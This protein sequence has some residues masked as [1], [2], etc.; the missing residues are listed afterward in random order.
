MRNK[1]DWDI[2]DVVVALHTLGCDNKWKVDRPYDYWGYDIY[3]DG[4]F[5][6]NSTAYTPSAIAGEVHSFINKQIEDEKKSVKQ[7]SKDFNI[8]IEYAHLVE[9][10]YGLYKG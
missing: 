1:K 4:I 5:L 10:K 8:E 7:L 9:K 6:L 3:F 2:K